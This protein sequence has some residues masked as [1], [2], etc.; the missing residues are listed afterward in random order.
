MARRRKTAPPP[1]TV[2]LA[3]L[4]IAWSLVPPH[5]GTPDP[6]PSHTISGDALGLLLWWIT[7]AR[8][9]QHGDA[10]PLD[11][12]EY[13]LEHFGDGERIGRHLHDLGEALDLLGVYGGDDIGA[14]VAAIGHVVMDL[15]ARLEAA[16]NDWR[17]RL[18]AS[19]L[20]TIRRNEGPQ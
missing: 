2:T 10:K 9:G 1:Q 17:A 15:G 11:L 14:P 8:G 7:R 16:S 12:S 19:A 6:E 20:V 13:V 18:G 3:D 5:D 4:R